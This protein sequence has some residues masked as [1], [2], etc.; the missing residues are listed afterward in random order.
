MARI[1]HQA[2]KSLIRNLLASLLLSISSP[3]V[4]PK[5]LS[6]VTRNPA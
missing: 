4:T 5:S 6:W 1:T 2:G 3:S